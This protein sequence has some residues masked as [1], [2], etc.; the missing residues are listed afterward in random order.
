MLG[1]RIIAALAA[2]TLLLGLLP[3]QNTHATTACQ[4]SSH[5]FDGSYYPASEYGAGASISA[6]VGGLCGQTWS[7]ASDWV[8]LGRSGS[9]TYYAQSGIGHFYSKSPEY[10]AEYDDNYPNNAY[11]F[12]AAGNADANTHTFLEVYNFSGSI[13]MFKDSTAILTTPF[14]PLIDWG[15]MVP[16]FLGETGDAGDDMPGSS[17]IPATF[18]APSGSGFTGMSIITSRTSGWVATNALT[19]VNT[20]PTRY[21]NSVGTSSQ[22]IWTK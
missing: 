19:P 5:Q 2:A 21:A 7:Q 15:T 12:Q 3:T 11:V 20:Y 16:S 9:N 14:D 4:G 10:F 8:M 17:F 18:S 1:S 6:A 22:S 13:T